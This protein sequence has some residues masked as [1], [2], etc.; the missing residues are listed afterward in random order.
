MLTAEG[1]VL[2][3]CN[4]RFGDPEAQVILP[5]LAVPLGPLLLAAAKGRLREAVRPLSIDGNRLPTMPG[6]CVG[7]VLAAAGYPDAPRSGRSRSTGLHACA[8]G[9]R[10]RVPRRND[11]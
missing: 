9:G 5:R 3:E 11:P 1:P 2:L 7:I 6:T 8:R 4:A 10:S